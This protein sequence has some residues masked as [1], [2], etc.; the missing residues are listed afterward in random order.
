MDLIQ[1][2]FAGGELS[3][4]V[5]ARS[6]QVKYQ[7]GLRTCLNFIIRKSGGV[8]NRPGTRYIAA[9]RTP[10]IG[11]DPVYGLLRFIF[12]DDQTYII[13]ISPK[14]MRVIKNGALVTVSATP[15]VWSNA[16]TYANGVC[17]ERFGSHYIS[18][19][20]GNLNHD[21]DISPTFWHLLPGATAPR[22]FEYPYAWESVGALGDMITPIRYQQSGDTLILALGG[23]YGPLRIVRSDDNVWY[24][25][26][27][28][29]APSVAAPTITGVTSGGAG[30]NSYSYVVTAIADS[31]F[32]ESMQ[33]NT[34]TI[35][36]AAVP[37]SGAPH[38]VNF[39][40]TGTEFDVYRA[41][42][43]KFGFIGT[44]TASP[45]NDVGYTPDMTITPPRTLNPGTP[46]VV[47]FVQQ[48][49]VMANMD[50]GGASPEPEKIVMSRTGK[51]TNFTNSLPSQDDDSV[52]FNL[53]SKKISEVRAIFEAGV[54]IIFTA[55]GEWVLLGG[56]DGTITPTTINAKQQ[57]SNGTSSRCDPV[58]VDDTVI[59][60][61][62][63]GSVV[64]DFKYS[65]EGDGYSGKDLSVYAD[66]LFKGHTII[67]LDYAQNPNSIIW[68]LRDDG[69]LLGLS[70]L[71]EHAVWGWHRHTTDGE[72]KDIAVIPEG[73]EDVLYMVVKRTIAGRDVYYIERLEPREDTIVED[74]FY[75]DCGLS[76]DG[77]NTNASHT[78][79]INSQPS[80]TVDDVVTVQSST[81][82]FVSGDVGNAVV[83]YQYDAD[84]VTVLESVIITFTNYV[85]TTQMQGT[86]NKNIATGTNW[87]VDT[88]GADWA[89]AVDEFTNLDHL[90]GKSVSILSDGNVISDGIEDPLYTVF[91]NTITIPR[92]GVRVHIGLPYVSDLETMDLESQDNKSLRTKPKLLTHVAALVQNTS[93]LKAGTS[94]D[95]LRPYKI[96]E[97]EAMSQPTQ[98]KTGLVDVSV[99]SGWDEETRV[100]IR[101]SDPLPCTVTAII[102]R[103]MI[104]G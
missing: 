104:G 38:V 60:V 62:A 15:P 77:R 26:G 24:V 43:G 48:R 30:A 87:M 11:Q 76:Y 54:P 83:F 13:E 73:Q 16:V 64:R 10:P 90:E 50:A 96:R 37:T 33:S 42:N 8:C 98:L 66:H 39:T 99:D 44:A 75:V 4:S 2:N 3:P 52:T 65:M 34:V 41:L 68:A 89:K 14:R 57:S 63:R 28:P 18:L 70:Y 102:P 35:N 103:P 80:M 88:Y 91:T 56:G 29:V 92:P 21:P 19:A 23:L 17:V 78:M 97:N 9:A 53:A 45:F 36:A 84:G 25:E 12:S 71:R 67:A 95:N 72:I 22:V 93:S 61:Q 59:Y 51:F 100:V 55:S 47:A 46:A 40:G 69:V 1:R 58:Q 79:R 94:F 82:Y 86:P 101:Q 49:L 5:Y 32:E 27:Y 20:A 74:A 81:G 6:D 7:T 85:S 31:T